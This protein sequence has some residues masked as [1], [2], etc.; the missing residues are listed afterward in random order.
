[1]SDKSERPSV[2]A[3]AKAMFQEYRA[4][5][6]SSL[7]QL[8][9]Y[10][11]LFA[12]APLLIF[13]TAF[14]GLLAQ[15]VGLGN[16]MSDITDWLQE[17]LPRDA[18]NALQEPIKAALETSPGS[19]L[20]VG[21]LLT[22][23]SAKNAMSALMRGLNGVYGVEDQRPWVRKQLVS[24]GMTLALAV[25]IVG[26]G[27]FYVL[28]TSVGDGVA[29]FV[30]LGAAWATVSTWLRWPIIAVLVVVAVTVLH[31]AGP[32]VDAPKRTF[33]PGAAF[34]VVMWAI[35]TVALRIYIGFSSGF[36]EAY[37][38]FGA[39]LAVIFWLYVMSLIILLGG[40]LNHVL[41]TKGIEDR[42]Q[43]TEDSRQRE[44]ERQESDAAYRALSVEKSEEA[45]SGQ[46]RGRVVAKGTTLVAGGLVAVGRRAFSLWRRVRAP[47]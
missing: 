33:V 17:N 16:S 47:R 20:S 3:L 8:I 38:I 29:D 31:I 12:L 45:A 23:W 34:T 46:R 22:L 18:A 13:L 36:S 14:A 6:L 15:Q 43:R 44:D 19:L 9:A 5:D 41:R 2:V 37:G 35:A 30:G 28:G 25:A 4:K 42:G 10:N 24:V 7:A 27:A 11:L 32:H 40:T 26:T 1:M 21:G 39:M